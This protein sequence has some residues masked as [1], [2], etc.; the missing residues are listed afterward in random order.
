[1]SVLISFA[2]VGERIASSADLFGAD[3]DENSD[4]ASTFFETLVYDLDIFE[5]SVFDVMVKG[6]KR[7]N[8]FKVTELPN[9]IIFSWRTS[10]CCNLLFYF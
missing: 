8:E 3:V 4:I 9:D 1:M 10:K 2:N 7:K 5:N 6:T